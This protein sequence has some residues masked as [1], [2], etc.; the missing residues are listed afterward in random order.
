MDWDARLPATW[1]LVAL[2]V[3]AHLATGCWQWWVGYD[4]LVDALFM[5]R[6]TRMRVAVGGQFGPLVAEGQVWRLW[7]SVLLHGDALHLL[8]NAVAIG[9]LGR[10]LEPWVG[11][12]R[13]VSWFA[14]GGIAG[15]VVTQLSGLLQS[16][17]AS[18]GAFALLGALVVVAWLRRDDLD[19]TDRRM[20]GPVLWGFVV[21]NLALSFALPFVNAA[22]HVGGLG[23]G[24]LVGA[25]WRGPRG[26]GTGLHALWLLISAG[27]VGWAVVALA[28]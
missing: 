27:M 24:L 20:L 5:G 10:V 6:S 28:G 21:L 15:A 23:A 26:W 2:L 8:V 17:G 18:G 19:A 11:S 16:D 3:I 4:D 7:T 14:L 1:G 9:T 12:L 25:A 22:G 13:L